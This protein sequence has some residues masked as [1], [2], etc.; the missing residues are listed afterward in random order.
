MLRK[1]GLGRPDPWKAHY[2]RERALFGHTLTPRPWLS[3]PDP[4]CVRASDL[5]V[6][7]FDLLRYAHAIDKGLQLPEHR[8]GFGQDKIRCIARMISSLRASHGA[9]IDPIAWAVGILR[10]YRETLAAD[11]LA[12]EQIED[13]L[14]PHVEWLRELDKMLMQFGE[15]TS[16]E[17]SVPVH[18]DLSPVYFDRRSVRQWSNRPV[19]EQTLRT[20]VEAAA[21]APASCNRQPHKFLFLRDR[22]S[23][24]L[25]LSVAV[26]GSGFGSEAPVIVLLLNDV[27]AYY[28]P[29]ER[30][31]AYVDTALAAQNLI[32]AAHELGIGTVWLSCACEDLGQEDRLRS[33]L[34]VPDWYAVVGAVALGYTDQSTVCVPSV[35]RSVDKMM[36]LDA[37]GDGQERRGAAY[38]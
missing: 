27:R 11:I 30:H 26:G 8:V 13:R 2:A 10:R 38:G 9:Y 7:E 35:R 17:A 33:A 6:V 14:Q 22:E 15:V 1:F 20:L 16:C 32:L 37:F 23:K 36:V 12:L 4:V 5:D 19:S 34:H 28:G 31:L 24:H 25:A 3:G 21:W 29:H 18:P